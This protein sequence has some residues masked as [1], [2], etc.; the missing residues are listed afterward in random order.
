MDNRFVGFSFL[1]LFDRLTFCTNLILL[2]SIF[3]FTYLYTDSLLI[4]NF[5][6]VNTKLWEEIKQYKFD[7]LYDKFIRQ[8][9][10]IKLITDLFVEQDVKFNS[11]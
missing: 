10:Q 4:R 6:Y 7:T 8:F 3:A 2:C 9:M 5:L 11:Q 1:D